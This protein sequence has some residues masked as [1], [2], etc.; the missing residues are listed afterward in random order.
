MVIWA[1]A[2]AP[3]H[4]MVLISQTL[5]ELVSEDHPVRLLDAFFESIDWRPWEAHYDGQRGQPPIHPRHMVAVILYGLMRRVRSSR[6]LEDAT[7]ERLDF[8]WLLGGRTI[9]HSTIAIF[10]AKFEKELKELNRTLS[11]AIVEHAG[12]AELVEMILDATRVRANSARDGAR[13]AAWLER[14]AATCAEQLNVKLAQMNQADAQHEEIEALRQEV[15]RLGRELDKSRGALKEAEK[16]DAAKRQSKGQKCKPVR[17]P[18]SDPDATILPNKEGGFAPNY[19]PMAA[20]E[21][22]SGAI[23]SAD[24]VSGG[25]EPEAVARVLEDCQ[26]VL[27]QKPDRVLADSNFASGQN[28]QMLETEKVEIYMPVGM[29]LSERNPANRPDLS[30][31]VAADR[32]SELPRHGKQL[33]KDAFRYDSTSDCYYCPMGKTLVHKENG[34]YRRTGTACGLYVCPG[35]ADCPMASCCVKG[36][37]ACRTVARDEH[38]GIRDRVALQMDSAAAAASAFFCALCRSR[39]LA[40]KYPASSTASTAA[41]ISVR[42]QS[43]SG[44]V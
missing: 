21:A 28:L 18:L 25:D 31:P 44:M 1:K 38:Q 36:D 27:D 33:S 19:T 15:A 6:D 20:V 32:R 37:A 40:P 35:K 22:K 12:A 14:F 39:A 41:Q 8:K 10:R 5:D 7:R 30:V 23:I 9:D 26:Y 16:R 29:D 24:V 3:R 42:C 4:Q 11:R 43:L 2:P 17:V 34:T 13:D